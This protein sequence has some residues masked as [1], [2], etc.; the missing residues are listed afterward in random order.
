MLILVDHPIP[1]H[2][3]GEIADS[4]VLYRPELAVVDEHILGYELART[5]PDALL[6]RRA[7]GGA[8]ARTWRTACPQQHLVVIM[9]GGK[10]S[11][12]L[13][14]APTGILSRVV[15]PSEDSLV[16]ALAA[17]EN[18]WF[19]AVVEA[20]LAMERTR[21]R[22]TSGRSVVMVGAGAVNLV[23][24]LRLAREG[25]EATIYEKSPDPRAGAHWEHYGCSRGGGDARMV[26]LTEADGYYFGETGGAPF[27]TPIRDGGWRVTG[28]AGL[29]DRELE[30]ISTNAAVPWWLRRCY[31]SDILL[32]NRVAGELWQE[33]MRDEPAAFDK[34]GL[35]KGILRLYTDEQHLL[36]EVAR[37]E[38][39]GADPLLLTPA[40]IA[41]R[42]PALG[43]AVRGQVVAGG[44]QVPGFTVQVHAFLA[45]LVDLLELSGVRFCWNQQV[46]QLRRDGAGTR[47]GLWVGDEPVVADHLV[48]S[49][50][51]YGGDLLRGTASDGLIHGVLGAWL[52][53]PGTDP[54]LEHSLKIGRRGHLAEDSNVTV[55]TGAD[56]KPQLIIGSGYGWTGHDPSNIDTEELDVLYDAVEDTAA[57]FFPRAF[58]EARQSGLLRKSR[59]F[60]LR[61]WTAS[62]LGVLEIA[63]KPG[64]GIMVVTGGHNTGGFAQAPVIA[65][66]VSAALQ[67]KHH[68]MHTRYHPDRL[69]AFLRAPRP[70]AADIENRSP[71]LD[72]AVM[73]QNEMLVNE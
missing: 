58:A 16:E 38:R 44:I 13:G 17:A 54:G 65:E 60:C 35:R 63:A 66:A 48:L 41:E 26:T 27:R 23:T 59:R 11:F 36:A 51:V 55:A 29:S 72:D 40:Q 12:P 10:D 7:F 37:Q 67:G 3:S 6:T 43:D 47:S 32:F 61:P 22:A 25:Y 31:T 42:H 53:L 4:A 39:V 5:R 50:G 70:P 49:T 71:D 62:S 21:A 15:T 20:K 52:T 34:V 57:T 9:I 33:L 68:L 64:G 73:T 1:D 46:S 18:A 24:A 69:R 8:A 2:S 28:P 45:G 56:G 30:W 19:D 14:G